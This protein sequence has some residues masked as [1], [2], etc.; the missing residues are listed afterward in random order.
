MDGNAH[1]RG[2]R[3][4]PAPEPPSDSRRSRR[5]RG[6]AGVVG[7]IPR[8]VVSDSE[9]VNHSSGPASHSNS[10]P[11]F[12][13]GVVPG[14][15]GGGVLEGP[16]NPADETL[17]PAVHIG[18]DGVAEGGQSRPPPGAEFAFLEEGPSRERRTPKKARAYDF[19]QGIRLGRLENRVA[20]LE[21]E[22]RRL[23][24]QLRPLRE[25]L[26]DRRM[27]MGEEYGLDVYIAG[28]FSTDED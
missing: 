24:G 20:Y 26:R 22:I 8:V 2:A 4:I 1:W 11:F 18:N 15:A 13:S 23:K 25:K 9:S 14:P 6:R 10:D 5:L 19:L 28:G 21:A 12:I 7:P 27:M 17:G 16:L 3:R